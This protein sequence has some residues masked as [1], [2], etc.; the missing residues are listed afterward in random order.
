M[1]KPPHTPLVVLEAA[2]P[3]GST[4]AG[5]T[6]WFYPVSAVRCRIFH[7]RLALDSVAAI[8][9]PRSSVKCVTG[10]MLQFLQSCVHWARPAMSRGRRTFQTA[11]YLRGALRGWGHGRRAAARAR[12]NYRK[13]LGSTVHCRKQAK[14]NRHSR[15]GSGRSLS[16]AGWLQRGV[17]DRQISTPYPKCPRCGFMRIW[18]KNS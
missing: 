17:I 12:G 8:R 13:A 1:R 16:Q 18:V 7:A 14:R 5:R 9:P 4:L 10:A 15:A 11:D 3:C 2:P 6:R